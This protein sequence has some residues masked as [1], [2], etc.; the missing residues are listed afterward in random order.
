MKIA[1]AGQGGGSN[2]IGMTRAM[3][4]LSRRAEIGVGI[5]TSASGLAILSL[6]L[7][8]DETRVDSQLEGAC[9]RNRIVDGGPFNLLRHGAWSDGSE[10]RRNAALLIDDVAEMG[11]ALFPVACVVADTWTRSAKVFSSWGTPKARVIDVACATAA[12]PY[13]FKRVKVRGDGCGHE[14]VDGGLVKNL[15]SSELDRF[16]LPVVSLRCGSPDYAPRQPKSAVDRLLANAALLM[17]ASN[18]AWTSDHPQSV[19][20]DVPAEDGF[21]FNLTHED[22]VRRRR[23]AEN[24]VRAAVLP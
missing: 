20:I 21:N 10:F 12:I 14:Y 2:V 18:T 5:G 19:V 7:G 3:R 17:E 9:S 1:L 6:A 16:G 15:A 4:V 22:C 13:V 23:L 24:A 11:D 8:L